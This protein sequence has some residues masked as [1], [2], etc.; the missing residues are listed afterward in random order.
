MARYEHLK[1]YK[2]AFDMVLY[3]ENIVRGFSRY[4]KYTLGSELRNLSRN[5]LMLIIRANNRLDKNEVLME[6][7]EKLE[8]LQVNL[9]ICREVKAFNNFNSFEVAIKN[10]VELSRQNEGWLRSVNK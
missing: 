2:S 9:R 8:E 7:R 3:F 5:V 4:N 6:I 1:I 10:V